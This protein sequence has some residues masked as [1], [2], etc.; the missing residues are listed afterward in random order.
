MSTAM[1]HKMLDELPDLYKTGKFGW[2]VQRLRMFCNDELPVDIDLS[3]VVNTILQT[4][5]PYAEEHELRET[6]LLIL[7]LERQGIL[8]QNDLDKISA[9]ISASFQE[10]KRKIPFCLSQTELIRELELLHAEG[11]YLQFVRRLNQHS[12][13]KLPSGIDISMAVEAIISIFRSSS[14]EVAISH[15]TGLKWQLERQNLLSPKDSDTIFEVIGDVYLNADG[16]LPSFLIHALL[17]PQDKVVPENLIKVYA[18]A[19]TRE[20]QF[21]LAHWM[22]AFYKDQGWLV[23]VDNLYAQRIIGSGSIRAILEKYLFPTNVSLDPDECDAVISVMLDYLETPGHKIDNMND[24]EKYEVESINRTSAA[25]VLVVLNRYSN[26]TKESRAKI[27]SRSD[28]IVT[29]YCTDRMYD[30]FQA[31]PLSQYLSGSIN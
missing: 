31:I 9:L 10:A 16:E 11:Q 3:I 5:S 26:T 30:A 19:K 22:G 21:V 17:S 4:F 6:A 20:A 1:S 23:L 13:E 15:A 8:D 14:G 28:L 2:I 24:E 27:Q 7:Q 29:Y 12:F 25:R 18:Q